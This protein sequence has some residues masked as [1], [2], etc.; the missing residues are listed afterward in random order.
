M[1]GR[2]RRAR[3][4]A[5]LCSVTDESKFERLRRSI[6]LLDRPEGIEV[7]IF[8]TREASS[9]AAA[10][11]RLLDTASDW[12][13]KVY[14]HQDVVIRNSN[15]IADVLRIF[16][17]RSIGLIG[18]AG[19][20]Y[21][22]DSCVWWDGSGLYG[23][24]LHLSEREPQMLEFEQPAGEYEVVEA[25]DGLAMITQHDL[26]WDE[27]LAGFNFYDV[28]QATRFVLAGYDVVV[29]RQPDAWFA[30]DTKLPNPSRSPEYI[31][32]RHA[33]RERYGVRREHFWQ[34]RLRRGIRRAATRL[35][36]R[37]RVRG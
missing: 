6:D 33:F 2:R 29:P 37:R 30:H 25:V 20:R 28:A 23:R 4:I 31:A 35:V 3:R 14:V 11:N 15:L 18:A 36:G 5:F 10:Y 17:R 1:K 13:Y 7:E 9:L 8:D 21:L 24:V 12:K 32:A 19:C 27:G 34:S 22:P 16:R 26:R